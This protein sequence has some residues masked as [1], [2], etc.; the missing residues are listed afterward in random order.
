MKHV[1]DLRGLIIPLT[2]LK[3]TQGLRKM[4]GGEM[5]EIIG[6]DP[7]TRKD[8]LRIL[9]LSPC[10]VLSVRDEEDHYHV[11]LKKNKKTLKA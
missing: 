6:T 7:D 8:L 9:G 4:S 5:M 1:L 2:L 11:L 10:E 3:I